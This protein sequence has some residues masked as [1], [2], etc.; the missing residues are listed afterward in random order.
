MNYSISKVKTFEGV[1]GMGFNCTVLCDGKPVAKVTDDAW[2]GECRWDWTDRTAEAPFKKMIAKAYP[3][4]GWEAD[5]LWVC[6]QIDVYEG[7]QE[8]NKQMSRKI[9]F[10]LKKDGVPKLF[11]VKRKKEV[12]LE[13]YEQQLHKGYGSDSILLNIKPVKERKAILAEY[14]EQEL[15]ELEKESA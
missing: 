9:L 1:E 15:A 2:G 4:E 12:T 5:D 14:I 10:I 3:D 13:S 11:A 7:V 8:Y 6:H